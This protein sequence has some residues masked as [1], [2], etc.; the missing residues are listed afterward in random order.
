VSQL[1]EADSPPANRFVVLER[2]VTHAIE[3]TR[4]RAPVRQQIL[5]WTI[6]MGIFAAALACWGALIAV[7]ILIY[8]NA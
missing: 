7:A 4:K 3:L 2:S 1:P 5:G 6:V 8:R